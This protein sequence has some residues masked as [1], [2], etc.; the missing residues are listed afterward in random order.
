MVLLIYGLGVCNQYCQSPK[1][2]TVN[3]E[4]MGKNRNTNDFFF[5]FFFFFFFVVLIENITTSEK[6][7]GTL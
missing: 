5:F 6:F 4:T 3:I 2:V 1:Y 7:L